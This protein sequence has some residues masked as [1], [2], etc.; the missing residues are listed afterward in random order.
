MEYIG[1]YLSTTILFDIY[2]YI[3]WSEIHNRV[4]T[5]EHIPE[6]NNFW[7]KIFYNYFSFYP[8]MSK[9]YKFNFFDTINFFER[10]EFQ[11]PEVMEDLLDDREYVKYRMYQ[12]SVRYFL[13]T[14][15]KRLRDDLEVMKMAVEIDAEALCEAS[16]RIQDNIDLVLTAVNYSYRDKNEIY[17]GDPP[18]SCA[19]KRLRDNLQIVSIA[20][21]NDGQNIIYASP[22]ALRVLELENEIIS[23]QPLF[24]KLYPSRYDFR[25]ARDQVQHNGMTLKYLPEEFRD[26]DE[27]VRLAVIQ[28]GAAFMFASERLRNDSD[29]VL[30]A[31]Q[32]GDKSV[33]DYAG[34][35]VLDDEYFAYKVM[36]YYP[37]AMQYLSD[38]LRRDREFVK[39]AI[40]RDGRLIGLSHL[41]GDREMALMA[42]RNNRDAIYEI[43]QTLLED[44][45]FIA[46]IGNVEI[47]DGE[48]FF[49]GDV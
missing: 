45:E 35:P 31:I 38:R 14:I 22:R 32:H 2:T 6:S 49:I 4:E 44:P 15:N 7:R 46:L 28:S 24:D 13:S 27:I 16:E 23:E 18:L 33:L 41:R 42:I 37:L 5:G 47:V 19:S 43:D 9:D 11:A 12:S 3:G 26:N 34:W 17:L 25:W 36:D 10:N 39:F 21:Q 40:E 20:I 1:H 48:A 8:N 30:L 29:M